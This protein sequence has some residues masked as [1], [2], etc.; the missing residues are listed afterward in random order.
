MLDGQL[1]TYLVIALARAAV[2]NGVC[3]FLQGNI[4]QPLGDAGPCVACAQQIVLIDCPSLHAGDDIVIHIFIR[5][6]QHIELGSPRLQCLLL[7]A[8]Q[9]IRLAHIACHGDD[10]AVVVVFLQ[11]GDDHRSVQ[12]AGICKNHFLYISFIHNYSSI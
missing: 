12:T 1:K 7:Q 6:I 5:Q 3:L 10:L 9:L 11:P 2:H 8:L 4:H